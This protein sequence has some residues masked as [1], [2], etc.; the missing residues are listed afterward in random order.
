MEDSPSKLPHIHC[1]KYSTQSLL[2]NLRNRVF[3]KLSDL[4]DLFSIP[5]HVDAKCLVSTKHFQYSLISTKNYQT[6]KV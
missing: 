3:H 6:E 4:S 1:Y 2:Q 5:I